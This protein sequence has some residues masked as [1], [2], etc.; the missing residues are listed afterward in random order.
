MQICIY[1]SEDY[2][3]K[4]ELKEYCCF[5]YRMCT[6]CFS[7]AHAD[8]SSETRSQKFGLILHLI[9]YS[10]DSVDTA[11]VAGSPEHPLLTQMELF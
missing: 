11:R 3:A 2:G 1:I 9:Q 10:G 8:I 5:A 6:N 4:F 7:N